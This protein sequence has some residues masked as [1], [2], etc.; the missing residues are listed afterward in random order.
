[1]CG[2]PFPLESKESK[3]Q[4][5]AAAL[6]T[7]WDA[8]RPAFR[9]RIDKLQR[10]YF[11][12]L[13]W[14]FFSRFICTLRRHA[15]LEGQ[16]VIRCPRVGHVYGKSNSWKT[17]FVEIAGKFMFGEHFQ[18]CHPHPAHGPAPAGDRRFVSP[19]AGSLL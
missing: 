9:G 18:G 13:C 6:A 11:I 19:H 5:D 16:D 1:M 8:Y 15:S 3:V 12:F 14:M 2:H 17:Q 4:K 7:F 10:A